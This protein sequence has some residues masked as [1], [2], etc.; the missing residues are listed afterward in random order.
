MAGLALFSLKDPSLLAFCGRA[1]DHNLRSVFGLKAIP[2]D[3]QMREILDEVHP[4]QLRPA[5]KEI[6]RQVQRGKV[7]EDYVFLEGCYLVALVCVESSGS[8]KVHCEPC[9]TR[10]HKTGAVP[11]Y[12]QMLGAVLVHPDFSAVIPLMPEPIQRQD[13]Q[14]KNDCE[15]NAARRWIKQFRK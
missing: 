8:Q 5:F 9:L 6:F 14:D 13:G 1:L 10:T 4:N 3:T 15:R 12:H 2:S 11:S 7:L